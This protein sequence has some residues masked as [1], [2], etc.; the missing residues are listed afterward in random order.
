MTVKGTVKSIEKVKENLFR[1]HGDSISLIENTY[2]G[3]AKRATFC[4]K[5]NGEWETFVYMVLGGSIHPKTAANNRRI[6]LLEIKKRLTKVHGNS[7]IIDEKTYIGTNEK[8]IFFH[9][10]K[11]KWEAIV[12]G[13]LSGGTH[14]KAALENKQISIDE[15]KKRLFETH[16]DRVS[17]VEETYINVTSK[18]TFIQKGVG[19]WEGDVNWVVGGG[20][21]PKYREFAWTIPE[22]EE[23]IKE[24]HGDKIRLIPDSYS[25]MAKKAKFID[26]VY[27]EFESTPGSIILG[28]GPLAGKEAKKKKTS[29]ERYGVN[30]PMQNREISIKSARSQIKSII[31]IHWKTGEE[32]VC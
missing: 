12:S 24:V 14:P 31:K 21:H 29:L 3:V 2:K 20:L 18:A 28:K 4:D 6:P 5:Q 7:I 9:I 30:S 17:I 26:H 19:S 1:I 11:G 32:L 25:G 23:K 15:V 8:A 13:V 16:G 27:G 10:E 22:V